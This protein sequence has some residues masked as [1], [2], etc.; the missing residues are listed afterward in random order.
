M[1]LA[2]NTIPARAYQNARRVSSLLF[3]WRAADLS[4]TPVT[5][6]TPTFV[7]ATAGGLVTDSRGRLRNVA[8]YQPRF[9]YAYDATTGLWTVPGLV[10]E[11]ART[12]VVLWCRKMTDAA[13][14]KTDVTAAFDQV[15]ADGAASSASKLTATGA[16]GTCLQAITLASSARYQSA[17]VKRI[18]GAGAIQM[19]TDGGATWT[20]V[21]L[22]SAWTRVTIPTQTLANPSVGFRLVTSGDAIAVDL[23]QNETGA[24]ASS[25]IPTTTVAVQRNADALS[26]PFLAPPRAM[27][28]YVDWRDV[29]VA[30]DTAGTYRVLTIGDAGV[31]SQLSIIDNNG[32]QRVYGYHD[33]GSAAVTATQAVTRVVGDRCEARLVLAATGAIYVGVSVNG[34]AEVVSSTT[35]ANALAAVWSSLNLFLNAAGAGPLTPGHHAFRSVKIAAG[36]KTMAEMREAF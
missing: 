17:Y 25:P 1:P 29:G 23:V 30:G 5:G 20:A 27:T 2:P 21:T 36:V 35:A 26:W 8:Q 7:R 24:F 31:G 33:N 11:G 28:V 9:D 15:G 14:V 18:T 13:W 32:S 3:H 6:E 34:G 10:L 16:N 12:N 19:T 22:T 4:L